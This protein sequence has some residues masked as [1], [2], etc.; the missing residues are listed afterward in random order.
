MRITAGP[1]LQNVAR[2]AITIMWHTDEPATSIV[3]YEQSPRL[4]WSAYEGRP[5]PTYPSPQVR[6]SRIKHDSRRPSHGT[7][8]GLQDYLY[9][10][11]STSAGGEFVDRLSRRELSH[12]RA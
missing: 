11:S 2:D 9:R 6:T 12:R 1:Y 3:E 4:G 7:E 10:V 8:N 5:E